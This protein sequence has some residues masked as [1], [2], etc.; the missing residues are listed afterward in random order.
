M[1][2][3]ITQL[4]EV[5]LEGREPLQALSQNVG[6]KSRPWTCINE[7]TQQL[8]TRLTTTINPWT[9]SAAMLLQIVAATYTTETVRF[10]TQHGLGPAAAFR[11]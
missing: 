1:V 3:G 9:G 5:V 2:R 6:G 10:E 7:N 8:P 4:I 11:S